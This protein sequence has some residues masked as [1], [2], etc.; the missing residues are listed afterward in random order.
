L[1]EEAKLEAQKQ[2]FEKEKETLEQVSDANQDFE[3]LFSGDL[4]DLPS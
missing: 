4:N 1:A 3:E 2:A